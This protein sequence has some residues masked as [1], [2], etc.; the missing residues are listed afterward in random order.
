MKKISLFIAFLL[1]LISVKGQTATNVYPSNL[2][3]NM[4]F[5]RYEAASATIK[6]L[7]F[8]VLSDGDNSTLKTPAFKVSLYLM[9]EGK[10]SLS[11]LIIIH[12]YQLDGIYHM[13]KH[14]FKNENI[15]LVGKDIAPG[16][17][18]LGIWV[19]SDKAFTENTSDNATLFQNTISITKN[20]SG[21]SAPSST[22]PTQPNTQP[23]DEDNDGWGD[24]GDDW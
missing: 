7:N 21:T 1:S 6:N 24:W 10:N 23:Q 2:E 3:E 19:N 15:S 20:P 16:N 18:R 9:P 17:Y 8:L 11:D 14:E 22:P 13:G 5:E 12:E 4:Y